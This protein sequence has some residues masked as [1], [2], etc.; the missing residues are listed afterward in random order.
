MGFLKFLKRD[1]AS[2]INTLENLDMPPPPP[3]DMSLESKDDLGPLPQF[4]EM[5]DPFAAKEYATTELDSLDNKPQFHE[6]VPIPMKEEPMDASVFEPPKSAKS[7]FD[8][9]QKQR[10]ETMRPLRNDQPYSH[11]TSQYDE[12]SRQAFSE[13]RDLLDHKRAG[14]GPVYVRIDRFRNVFDGISSVRTLLKKTSDSIQL[15]M[16]KEMSRDRDYDKLKGAV[17]DVQK[18]LLFVEQTIFKGD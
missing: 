2:K 8:K 18:K 5:E 6:D 11:S 1:S 12:T 17:I 7:L 3:E 15:T 10:K 4:P 16:D 13:E 9:P 14:K